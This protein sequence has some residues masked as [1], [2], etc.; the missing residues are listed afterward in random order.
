MNTEQLKALFD[1]CERIGIRTVGELAEFKEKAEC[2]TNAELLKALKEV[3][4]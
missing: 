2:R 3:S 1:Y 4:E